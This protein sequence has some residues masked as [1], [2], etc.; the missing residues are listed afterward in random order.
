[1]E[2]Q[3]HHYGS[4][5]NAVPVLSEFRDHPADLYLLRVGYA[6]TMGPLAN[7][8][9]EGFP[10]SAFHAHPS[11]LR[12]DGITGDYGPGFL[13][14]A[15]ETGTYVARHPDLGWLAFGGNLEIDGE[16]VRI[17]PLDS[18]RSRVYLAPLG[19][20]LTLDAGTF[21]EVEASPGG[22]R[23]VL[24]PAS[25]HTTVARLRIE[26]PGEVSGVGQFRPAGAYEMERGAFRVPLTSGPTPLLL[27]QTGSPSKPEGRSVRNTFATGRGR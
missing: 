6:G 13:G 2:R 16:S 12:I 10:P 26:Q 24:S 19:L 23:L 14:H 27:R 11:T 7:I 5:L 15:L 21:E 3:L 20:W 22:L 17:R 25:S 9:R 4:A 8:T 1:V 18:A